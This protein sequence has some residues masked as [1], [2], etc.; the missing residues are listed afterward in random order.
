MSV[1]LYYANSLELLDDMLYEKAY[2]LVSQE[3]KEKLDRIK[4]I[5]S[6]CQSLTCELLLKKALFDR[7]LNPDSIAY[8]YGEHG[9]PFLQAYPMVY[10][11]FAHSGELAVCAISSK[12]VG[13]DVE[14][15]GK[16]RSNVASRFLTQEEYRQVELMEENKKNEEIIRYWTWKESFLKAIGEGFHYPL[17]AFSFVKAD[18]QIQIHQ[19]WDKQDYYFREYDVGTDYCCTVCAQENDFA[20]DTQKI[21]LKELLMR[22]I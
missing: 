1:S 21:D 3:R 16:N 19:S 6:C 11:N 20:P 9:K 22:L 18:G 10:F 17:Q 14:Q 4:S 2:S 8:S 15:T 5:K 7:G 12:E 13:C